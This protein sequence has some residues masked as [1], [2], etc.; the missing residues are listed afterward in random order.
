MSA[1]VDQGLANK[2]ALSDYLT[3]DQLSIKLGRKKRT[4]RLWRQR[5]EGPP[6]VKYG[7]TIVYPSDEVDPWL[8][9]LIQHPQRRG[10]RAA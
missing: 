7:P 6:W 8:R 5:R 1:N 9:S 4:L 3:E 10:K 2:P